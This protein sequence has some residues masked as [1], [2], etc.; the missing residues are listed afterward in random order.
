MAQYFYDAQIRRFLYQFARMFSNYEVEGG[1]DDNGKVTLI[2]VPVRYGDASRQAQS[3]LQDNSAN[4]LPASPLMSFYIDT[5]KHDRSRIQEPNFIDRKEVKQR[6]WDEASQT[7]EH[8][9]GNAFSVE[10][11]MPVP[12]TLGIKLD[13]WTSS[14]GMKLQLIEQILSI[15]RLKYRA[16]I[17]ILTGLALAL[18]ISK[19]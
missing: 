1:I 7:Y 11:P 10:R 3:I 4:N 6:E 13:I 8:I 19:M 5:L 9:Q 15:H 2:R 16:L 14:T 17:I 18:W 12:Y